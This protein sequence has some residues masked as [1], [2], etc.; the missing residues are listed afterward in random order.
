MNQERGSSEFLT[1]WKEIASYL[2]KGVRTVQRW[3]RD[4]GLPVR[5]PAQSRH[6]VVAMAS[7]LNQWIAHLQAS[8]AK[9]CTCREELDQARQ[10]IME[11]QRKLACLEVERNRA[12]M[13]LQ[14][15]S[16]SA[17]SP[18]AIDLFAKADSNAA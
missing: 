17:E 9:C 7:D 6:I 5:R 12:V 2:G 8:P 3:E 1:S 15:G 11:L 10:A 16:A 18:K 4:L 14:M 13:A